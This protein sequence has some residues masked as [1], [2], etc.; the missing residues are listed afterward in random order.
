V[1]AWL[2]GRR[3]PCSSTVGITQRRLFCTVCALDL[4]IEVWRPALD[5]DV[6]DPGLLHVPVELRLELVATV[7]PDLARPE[8]EAL[9]H[10]VS[11]LVNITASSPATAP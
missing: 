4:G 1:R 9:E 6:P 8:R 3:R 5:V 7:G 2:P 10:V 11:G